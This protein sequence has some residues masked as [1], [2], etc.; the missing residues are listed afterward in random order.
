ML[1]YWRY[2]PQF[3]AS[4]SKVSDSSCLTA[5]EMS[6]ERLRALRNASRV[7][8]RCFRIICLPNRANWILSKLASRLMSSWSA[9]GC[10][11]RSG[12]Y[13]RHPHHHRKEIYPFDHVQI[14]DIPISPR[15]TAIVARRCPSLNTP[16]RVCPGSQY[17][18]N[19]NPQLIYVGWLDGCC[20]Q[21][22]TKVHNQ[23]G[24]SIEE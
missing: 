12:E 22:G 24:E 4:R 21:Y 3:L 10:Y 15:P 13:L 2:I 17:I 14:D 9:F 1:L 18:F 19:L 16:R 5:H 20:L 6:E 8:S 7:S 23:S 11:Y